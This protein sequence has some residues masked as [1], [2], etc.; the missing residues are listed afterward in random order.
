M[1][2]ASGKESWSSRLGVIMAVAGS[3][4]GLGNFLRF[5]GLVADRE[6]GGGAFLIAYFISLLLVG[7]PVC[8]MEWTLGRH[9]GVRG[10]NSSPGIFHT[11][12]NKPWGKYV[13]LLGFM[14]PVCVYLYYVVIESWCLGYAW[15][16][17]GG[18]LDLGQ[19]PA[20]YKHF[21]GSFTGTEADGAALAWKS[22]LPFFVVVFVLNFIV[23]Y[24]GI[25]KGIEWVCN[26]GMPLLILIALVLLARVMTLGTPDPAHPELSV[27]NGLGYMW[28]PDNVAKGLM[29]PVVW[30]KAAGQ[31]F[32]TLSV[33]FGVIITYASYLKQNDDI[34]LSGLTASSANE[35]CE[36]ALGGLI[37]VPAAYAFLGATA[38][39]S[40]SFALGFNVLPQVFAG[41]PFG[42]VFGGLFFVLLFLA[43]VTSSLSMLQPG[44]A[45]L[46]EGLGLNRRQSVTFLGLITA[47]GSFLVIYFSK[48]LKALD[49]VDFWI[50]TVGIFVEGMLLV[51]VFNFIFGVER[52]WADAH[53][54]AELK[55]PGFYKPIMRW[56]TPVFLGAIFISFV[57][58]KVFGWN[59]SIIHPEF[60]PSEYITDLT[61][62]ADK[63]ADR[64]ALMSV[65]FLATV[66]VFLAMLI[67][68]A[69]ER[70]GRRA[71]VAES[72][73]PN[74]P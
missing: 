45:F 20:A 54:G 3:A 74:Q 17:F 51:L 24:R 18:N 48:D 11:V 5:P 60:K 8:W 34:V 65:I 58:T 36:V 44:I 67:H 14:V 23:I 35:F 39:V 6:T 28:N 61:G 53:K 22:T 12:I 13:G 33:G 59:F 52:G 62:T 40:S 47:L 27:W 25:S 72:K 68:Q 4:V 43:A 2:S 50:G 70:W 42:H 16:S 15:H 7:I 49:T 57:L 71:A 9:G 56:I 21:F 63:P 55:I 10:Y 73:T 32:F 66:G 46:E 37:T 41:M 1:S 38:I 64:V 69:G 29:N 30:L 31:I 26:I 19:N